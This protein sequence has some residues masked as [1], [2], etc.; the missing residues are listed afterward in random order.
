MSEQQRASRDVTDGRER[1]D[2]VVATSPSGWHRA[3]C[4]HPLPCPE[5]S[6]RGHGSVRES[7]LALYEHGV[8]V[9]TLFQLAG[10]EIIGHFVLNDDAVNIVTEQW[11]R[12]PS[13]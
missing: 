2:V 11:L 12:G 5:H 8:F 10:D 1:C 6:D 9:P 3:K 4:G 7:L 13:S